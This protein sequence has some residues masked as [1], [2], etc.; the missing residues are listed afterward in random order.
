M[1]NNG[2]QI[3]S[4]SYPGSQGGGAILPN[5]ELGKAQPREYPDIIALPPANSTIDVVLNE[6]KGMFSKSG[7]EKD[8]EKILRYKAESKLKA[9]LKETLFVA[10]VIDK[11]KQLK[12]IVIGV[13]FGMKN[14]TTTD[15]QPDNVD[16][17]FRIVNR[18]QWAIG[19]FKQE[20]RDLIKKIEGKTTFPTVYKLAKGADTNPKLF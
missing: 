13:A 16:F 4:V 14:G 15:W 11:N 19:I 9:A 17:I 18:N 7:L 12:N 20:M 10:Q 6:S 8:L 2:F 3:V 5:P 1:Q